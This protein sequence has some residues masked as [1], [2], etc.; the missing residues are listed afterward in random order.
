MSKYF[1][2]CSIPVL[3]H[4]IFAGLFPGFPF[5]W[6]LFLLFV[7]A[8]FRIIVTFNSWYHFVSFFDK[9]CYI[10]CPRVHFLGILLGFL[11]SLDVLIHLVLLTTL[12]LQEF[13]HSFFI[14]LRL[15]P[16][17]LPEKESQNYEAHS[18]N[19]KVD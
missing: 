18:T 4:L 15:L 7:T 8:Y 3:S 1:L 9:L 12:L 14:F 16:I 2:K 17:S 11:Y 10:L 5:L 6:Y 19:E 13:F